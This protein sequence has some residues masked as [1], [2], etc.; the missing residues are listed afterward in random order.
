[1]DF[2]DDFSDNQDIVRRLKEKIAYVRS[3]SSSSQEN[4]RS[5]RKKSKKAMEE[6]CVEHV[7]ENAIYWCKEDNMKV[8]KDC[9]IFGDHRGHTA[10]RGNEMRF[11]WRE[12]NKGLT[13]ALLGWQSQG[14]LKPNIWRRS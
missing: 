11:F 9:L 6:N 4:S 8:C 14:T 12:N 1:M 3:D 7:G 10:L 5:C 2:K 13:F